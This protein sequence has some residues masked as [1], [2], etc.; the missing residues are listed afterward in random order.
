MQAYLVAWCLFETLS[1]YERWSLFTGTPWF[2]TYEDFGD[3]V[4]VELQHLA[5]QWAA[6]QA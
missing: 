5:N 3:D 4:C 1:W 6:L 2:T